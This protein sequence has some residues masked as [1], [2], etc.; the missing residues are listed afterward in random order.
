M[1]L[2]SIILTVTYV[3]FFL[4]TLWYSARY[5]THMLQLNGYK[6]KEHMKWLKTGMKRQH[7]V[8][9]Y[10][11]LMLV[12]SIL[13]LIINLSSWVYVFW[14]LI[15]IIPFTGY[16]LLKRSNTKK[17]LVFTKRVRR[18]IVAD[19]I[20]NAIILGA[21]YLA[22]SRY[23]LAFSPVLLTLQPFVLTFTNLLLKPVEKAVNNS[24]IKDAKRRLA[25]S[26]SLTVIGVTGSYGKTSLKF[27]LQTLLSTKYNVLVTPESFNTPMGVVRTIREQL[28]S[29]HEIFICEMG[30]RHVGDIKEICDIVHPQH[31]VITSVGPQHLETFFNIDN[32]RKTK[33]ELADALPKGGKLFLNADSE[34][35]L[36][37]E[38]DFNKIY[39][40][41]NST[42]GYHAENVVLTPLGTDFT[43]VSPDGEKQEFHTQLIGS[44]NVLNI[45]GAISIAH[46]FGVDFATLKV[47]VRRIKPVPHRLELKEAGAVTIIDDAF[48]S[49]PVG[50][51]AAVETLKLFDGTRILI[52]PGMVELGE[53]ENE[54]HYKFGTYA[55]S[56]CDY[57]LLVN[58][59]RTGSIRQG[60]LDSDFPSDHLFEFDRFTEAYDFAVSINTD[61]HKYILLENDLPD[62]Y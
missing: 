20:L 5:N 58:K 27:Y 31:G 43:V 17:K 29:T 14:I 57:I 2:L 11:A 24:F 53:K 34:E 56:C 21:L 32:V 62:N 26:P 55:A 8:L 36:K 10:L 48:N 37:D 61:S 7:F 42:L 16:V 25:A 50:S 60:A 12:L 1:G 3:V 15:L 18:L 30:A 47:A 19:F 6:N 40:G 35:I 51:K 49:N 9:M 41:V 59:Y 22:G 45:V 13:S 23:F 39:Y 52:T 38:R 46:S 44:I 28:K 54:L 4:G 33:F